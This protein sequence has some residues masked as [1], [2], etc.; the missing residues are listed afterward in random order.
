[1]IKCKGVSREFYSL[2]FRAFLSQKKPCT[3]DRLHF[4]YPRFLYLY[5]SIHPRIKA[6][7]L[8]GPRKSPVSVMLL[9]RRYAKVAIKVNDERATSPGRVARVGEIPRWKIDI[10]ENRGRARHK[11]GR[12]FRHV[13]VCVYVCVREKQKD[14]LTCSR[15]TTLA[16]VLFLKILGHFPHS[17]FI[18]Y[19]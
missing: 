11:R 17:T 10:R 18:S 3:H 2:E 13:L 16:M 14:E 5:S 12:R 4:A 6:H 7:V 1:M 9:L 15:P 8:R 19:C